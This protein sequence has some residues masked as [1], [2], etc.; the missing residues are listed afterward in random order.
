M[1]WKWKEGK[2]INSYLFFMLCFVTYAQPLYPQSA[3]V[4][5]R[6]AFSNFFYETLNN[7]DK[8]GTQLHRKKSKFE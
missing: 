1:N 6:K 7:F 2:Q 8:S 3:C 5:N 4:G